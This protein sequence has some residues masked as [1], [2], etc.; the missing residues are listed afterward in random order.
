[1]LTWIL[2]G[3]LK[4][5]SPFGPAV[6][7][8]IA[9]IKIRVLLSRLLRRFAQI[10]YLNRQTDKP[11]LYIDERGALLYSLSLYSI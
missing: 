4:K 3:S 1:M 5:L 2:E 8:A 7:P 10:F 9:D 11:N 6:W